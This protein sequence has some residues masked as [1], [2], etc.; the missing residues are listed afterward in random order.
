M[1]LAG[2]AVERNTSIDS[3]GGSMMVVLVSLFITLGKENTI[4]FVIVRATSVGKG[5]D[6]FGEYK[7]EG[8]MKSLSF[9]H[10][11]DDILTFVSA[12]NGTIELALSSSI[13]LPCNLL[14]MDDMLVDFAQIGLF[15]SDNLSSIS[16]DFLPTHGHL[17]VNMRRPGD[18]G[19]LGFS[20]GE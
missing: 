5:G 6:A 15:G 8:R 2:G 19:G 3:R 1:I 10:V 18:G 14:V 16:K 20:F 7:V 9:D 13:W 4:G 11:L 17:R 12:S